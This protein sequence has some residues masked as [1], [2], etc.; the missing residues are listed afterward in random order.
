MQIPTETYRLSCEL[1]HLL[2]ENADKAELEAKRRELHRALG[3]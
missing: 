1:D 2:N 3:E